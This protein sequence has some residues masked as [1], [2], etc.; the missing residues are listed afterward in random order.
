[1]KNLITKYNNILI[2]S[3]KKYNKNYKNKKEKTENMNLQMNNDGATKRVMEVNDRSKTETKSIK[4]E[5]II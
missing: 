1:M 2:Y 4:T 3:N 5:R